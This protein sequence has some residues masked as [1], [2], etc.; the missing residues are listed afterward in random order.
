MKVKVSA[1]GRV[2]L[3]HSVRAALGL[4]P[5]SE[6]E[7]RVDRDEIVL[8]RASRFPRVTILEA[9]GCAGY[10]GTRRSLEEMNDVRVALRDSERGRAD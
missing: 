3:P 1:S 4:A 5:G 8:R 2:T 7:I 10:R 6:V 9:L